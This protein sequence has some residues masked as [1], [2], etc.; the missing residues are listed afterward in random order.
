MPKKL[1]PAKHPEK[2]FQP[3]E[4]AFLSAVLDDAPAEQGITQGAPTPPE[5]RSVTTSTRAPRRREEKPKALDATEAKVVELPIRGEEDVDDLGEG[6]REPAP[7]P[8]RFTRVLKAKISSSEEG[9]ISRIVSQLKRELDTPVSTTHVIRAL[10]TILRHSEP[11]LMRRARQN[12]PMRRPSN[13][14]LTGI[15][16]FEFRLAKLLA[17]AFRDAPALRELPRE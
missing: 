7:M 10:V 16:A 9:E 8:E 13:E 15:A 17:A 1:D 5:A 6:T 11:S 12:G 4:K 3:I 14:D 2:D